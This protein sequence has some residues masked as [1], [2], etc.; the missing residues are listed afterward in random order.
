MQQLQQ[1]DF[2]KIDGEIKARRNEANEYEDQSCYN[3]AWCN[4]FAAGAEFVKKEIMRQ[5]G[6]T[7]I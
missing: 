3:A 7:K 6:E 5:L 2:G 4:G 1:V